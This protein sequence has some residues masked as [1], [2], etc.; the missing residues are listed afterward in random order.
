MA[1]G[2][3]LS[4]KLR[5]ERSMKYGNRTLQKH[6]LSVGSCF[7]QATIP[8]ITAPDPVLRLASQKEKHPIAGKEESIEELVIQETLGLTVK[9][10]SKFTFPLIQ[11]LTKM[12]MLDNIAL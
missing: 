9:D 8:V 5:T 4:I 7:W 2:E 11:W 12:D 3:N 10:T 6:A 1:D